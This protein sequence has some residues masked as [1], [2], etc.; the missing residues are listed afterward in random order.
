MS[1][2]LKMP[3]DK[4]RRPRR[5]RLRYV[6]VLP[7]LL[8]LGNLVCGF[9]A[10][11]FGL[12]AMYA[13]GAGISSSADATLNSQLVE[14]MLPS[15]LSIGAMLV[16]LGMVFDMLDGLAAR[17]TKQTTEF[18]AEIDSLADVVTFGVAPAVL[19][20][21]L[22]MREWRSEYI[23][24]PLSE[25][26]IGRLMWVCAAVYCICAAV[27]LAHY[28]VEQAASGAAHFSFRGLPSPGAAAVVCSIVT[29]HEHL[30]SES[31]RFTLLC[32]LPAIAVSL[33]YLMVSRVRYERL[34]HS[35]LTRRRPFE[36]IILVLLVFAV[37][38]TYKAQ[39]L[40]ALCLLYAFSGP[41]RALYLRFRPRTAPGKPSPTPENHSL[42]TQSPAPASP[43][44]LAPDND[45][46]SAG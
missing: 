8:T 22:M 24:T 19:A 25:H 36:H 23:V 3:D 46:T 7:T 44:P 14:R 17:M 29:L 39:T 42:P 1:N 20:V 10:V 16:F 5:R 13:A 40:A 6:V 15:F 37:F 9:A 12:R 11:H 27:R 30:A 33:A 32:S 45:K 41:A 35:Y 38:L 21:S 31:V 2:I 4:P 28:N 34:T 18:G 26:L 43:T